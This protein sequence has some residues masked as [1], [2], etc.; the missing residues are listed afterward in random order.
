MVARRDGKAGCQTLSAPSWAVPGAYPADGR[1][2]H[3]RYPG[4]KVPGLLSSIRPVGDGTQERRLSSA[5]VPLKPRHGP[6]GAARAGSTREASL[7]RAGCSGCVARRLLAARRGHFRIYSPTVRRAYGGQTAHTRDSGWEVRG[8]RREAVD[9]KLCE[10]MKSL[11]CARSAAPGQSVN[12]RS[13]SRA[14]QAHPPR[15]RYSGESFLCSCGVAPLSPG[16]SVPTERLAHARSSVAPIGLT[17][18]AGVDRL[19]GRVVGDGPAR[20]R[21]G[22]LQVPRPGAVPSSWRH[23][24]RPRPTD[25]AGSGAGQMQGLV[26][27]AG[28]PVAAWSTKMAYGASSASD[29]IIHRPSPWLPLCT[30]SPS[31]PLLALNL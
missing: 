18:A 1:M 15:W 29:D 13:E 25:R 17:S 9:A 23:G 16:H 20:A 11:C 28:P 31:L 24:S 12:F 14:L 21:P 7:C 27:A 26:A 2:P 19:G 3:Q 22:A 8:G 10:L 6:G 5:G 4:A 30:V